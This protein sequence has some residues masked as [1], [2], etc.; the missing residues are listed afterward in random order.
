MKCY[1]V[2]S[3]ANSPN[4]KKKTFNF[5]ERK[6]TVGLIMTLLCI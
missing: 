1:T 2:K 3:V 4:N 6:I 5:D